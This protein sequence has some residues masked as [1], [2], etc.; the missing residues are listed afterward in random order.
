MEEQALSE[1]CRQGNSL[2]QKELYEGYADRL[3][4]LCLRYV[5]DRDVAFDVCQD[6]FLKIFQSMNKFE[7]KGNG[8]L[9]AWMERVMINEALQYLRRNKQTIDRNVSIEDVGDVYDTPDTED[10]EQIP[11]QVLL[12]FIGELPEGYRTV[13][14]L[15]AIEGKS[16][17]EIAEL[18][19][20]NEKSSASQYF[21]AKTTL[22]KR[23]K[24]W[25]K[26]NER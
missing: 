16:H 6:G 10:V 23:I 21:R 9:R 13:F 18:L 15:F 3:F 8:S 22:A 4:G 1:K 20:I 24:E 14:N 2:A 12:G 17:K 11:E 5:S 19:H 26:A 7:W 25:T